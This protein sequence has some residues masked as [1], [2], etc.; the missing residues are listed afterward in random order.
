ME[1]VKL[2]VDASKM[3]VRDASGNVYPI[4]Y[5]PVFEHG[6][7]EAIVSY[8]EPDEDPSEGVPQDDIVQIVYE[9]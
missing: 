5:I 6:D 2:Y 7:A 9:S 4:V 1:E 3:E 8:V